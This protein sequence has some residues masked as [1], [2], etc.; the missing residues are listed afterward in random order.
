LPTSLTKKQK[1]H[2]KY[3][4]RNKCIPRLIA[5]ERAHLLKLDILLHYCNGGVVCNNCGESDIDVLQ[6]DH[7]NGGGNQQRK[8]LGLR[9]GRLYLWMIQN[10]YP[11]GYQ[12]LCANCNMRKARL[13]RERSIGNGH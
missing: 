11:D 6:I 12:V 3:L 5:R 2:E 4:R 10:G 8:A 9:G 1:A 7:I 13:E